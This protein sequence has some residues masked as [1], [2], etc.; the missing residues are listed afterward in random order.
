MERVSHGRTERNI[1]MKP[2]L[3]DKAN[4]ESIEGTNMPLGSERSL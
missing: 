2:Q 1:G 3:E 4:T